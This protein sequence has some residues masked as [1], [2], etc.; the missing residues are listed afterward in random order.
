M[1]TREPGPVW[2]RP[3]PANRPA[4]SPL[5]RER[6]VRAAIE[7][8]DESGLAAVSIRK[9][10][11]VLEA[12]PMRLYGYVSTKEELFDLMVDAVYAELTETGPA[13]ADWRAR[14][15]SIA[16]GLRAATL[17]HEWFAE[18]I[19]GRPDIGPNGLAQL[20]TAYSVFDEALDI[21]TIMLAVG[22]V[23]SYVLGAVREEL[24]QFRAER[25][26]G[27]DE[28]EWQFASGPYLER[29]LADGDYPMLDR[30]VAEASHPARDSVFSAGLEAVLDGV[31]A[32]FLS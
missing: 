10:A 31:E 23:R 29:M 2:D 9:V 32:R 14:L 21:D 5:S 30:V 18:L 24:A 20:E 4:P 17:R 3:E 15:R 13:G 25:R 26:T 7:L 16:E 27:M 28:R 1:A 6:I 11:A 19:G 8:A 12:G 22:T